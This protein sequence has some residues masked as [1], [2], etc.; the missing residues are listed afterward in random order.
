MRL[1]KG[2]KKPLEP[3]DEEGDGGGGGGGGSKADK[4]KAKKNK[5][6]SRRKLRNMFVDYGDIESDVTLDPDGNPTKSLVRACVC[7]CTHTRGVALIVLLR[8]CL[9]D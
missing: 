9:R 4:R 7:N 3:V 6:K 8:F 5:S 1:Q 2:K